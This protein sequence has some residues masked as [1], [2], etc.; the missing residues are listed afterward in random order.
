MKKKAPG[1]SKIGHQIIKKLPDNIIQYIL[2]IFNASLA[3]GYFPRKFKSAI[4]KLLPKEGKDP[5]LPQNYRPIALLDNIGKL[6]EKIINTRIRKYLEE[7]NL[8]NP[9]QYGFRQGKS[10]THVIN[11]IHECIKHNSEQGFRTAILSKDVQKAFDTVW[12]SGLVW[13]I[14]HKFNLPMP[15]KKLLTSF[16]YDRTVKVKH[17]HY[18]STPFTPT[19]GVPQGSAL[20][21]TLYTM[22]THDLPKPHYRDSMTFAY[23]DDVTHIVRAKSTKAL[24][25]KVQKETDQVTKWERKWLIKT[26]PLKSQ[27]SFT[28][29]RHTT[30]QRFPPVAIVDNNNPTPIPTKNLQIYLDTELTKDSLELNIST[31]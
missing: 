22:Y 2:V 26:N 14:H 23:A 25:K 21:P 27:L 16:L 15:M 30:I 12:H 17:E 11:M 24:I 3:S 6:F 18:L 10:T 19:A 4:L 20:S 5:K 13:K 1:E 28:K 9:Q 8:Y 7:N 31:L 29:T